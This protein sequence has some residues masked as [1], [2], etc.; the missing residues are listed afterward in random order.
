GARHL[1]GRDVEKRATLRA[2]GDDVIDRGEGAFREGDRPAV[3][4]EHVEGLR[5]G[6]FVNEVQSYEELR[7]AARKR[8]HGVRVPHFFK[9]GWHGN[10][11]DTASCG[12]YAIMRPWTGPRSSQ[13]TG[14]ASRR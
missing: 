4:A 13:S 6:D 5:A 8:P 1:L 14:S 12:A 9:Q 3:L 7:L 11:N 10:P 2:G